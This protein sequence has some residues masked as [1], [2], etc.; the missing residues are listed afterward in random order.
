MFTPRSLPLLLL[1]LPLL[2]LSCSNSSTEVQSA[3]SL[4]LGLTAAEADYIGLKVLQGGH[5]FDASV[6]RAQS[7]ATFE[8]IVGIP[9]TLVATA[10]ELDT[11]VVPQTL[12]A[13]VGNA[14]FTPISGPN[15]LAMAMPVL[16]TRQ[17]TLAG[18]VSGLPYSGQL[19]VSIIDEPTNFVFPDALQTG[20]T[21]RLPQNRPLTLV[22]TSPVTQSAVDIPLPVGNTDVVLDIDIGPPPPP[23]SVAFVTAITRDPT[24]TPPVIT[25]PP[26]FTPQCALGATCDPGLAWQDCSQPLPL[27]PTDATVVVQVHY[28]EAP[29]LPCSTIT[30]TVDRTAPVLNGSLSPSFIGFGSTTPTLT[31]NS[32]EPLF[33]ASLSAT[34]S[35]GP[36]LCISPV[37]L[38]AN[39]Y[40][41]LLDVSTIVTPGDL[42][43]VVSATDTAG[44]ASTFT[45]TL[46][47]L[48]GISHPVIV[49][50]QTFPDIPDLI[51]G[52]FY[53]AVD[54]LNPAPTPASNIALS[55]VTFRRP[56]NSADLNLNMSAATSSLP[57]LAG[58]PDVSS[59]SIG[60][61]WGL[62]NINDNRANPSPGG[63]YQADIQ[64]SYT[65]APPNA[66]SASLPVGL[67]RGD[68]QWLSNQL[69]ISIATPEIPNSYYL[70]FFPHRGREAREFSFA[71]STTDVVV[72]D[73]HQPFGE[74]WGLFGNSVGTTT[75]NVTDTT[76]GEIAIASV[77]LD[78]SDTP[79]LLALLADRLVVRRFT[80]SSGASTDDSI[81]FS[82]TIGTT[83]RLLWDSTRDAA[84]VVG[85]NGT[86]TILSVGDGTNRSVSPPYLAPCGAPA[87]GILDGALTAIQPAT[88]LTTPD[89]ALLID[90]GAGRIHC[91]VDLL[92][93]AQHMS[94]AVPSNQCSNTPYRLTADPLT[95][96]FVA[97]DFTCAVQYHTRTG[98]AVKNAETVVASFG[99]ILNITY[100]PFTNT[101]AAL[102]D[103][104]SVPT[105]MTQTTGIS[106]DVSSAP[107]DIIQVGSQGTFDPTAVAIDPV[108]GNIFVAAINDYIG[109][110]TYFAVSDNRFTGHQYNTTTIV[111]RPA[112]FA[113]KNPVIDPS[114]RTMYITDTDGVLWHVA[115]GSPSGF[116]ANQTA[117][118]AWPFNQVPSE[119]VVAGPQIVALSA[120]TATPGSIVTAIGQGFVGGGADEVFVSGIAA[121]VL[122]STPHAV[123]FRVP[124]QFAQLRYYVA[125]AWVT[126]RSHGRMSGPAP[127]FLEITHDQPAYALSL[128]PQASSLTCDTWCASPPVG[129][130][131]VTGY[132]QLHVTRGNYGYGIDEINNPVFPA[133]YPV[134]PHF[135]DTLPGYNRLQGINVPAAAGPQWVESRIPTYFAAPTEPQRVVPMSAS[136]TNIGPLVIDATGR[137]LAVALDGALELFWATSLTPQSPPA[138][139]RSAPA[140]LSHLAFTPDSQYLVAF[141]SNSQVVAFP[142][143]GGAPSNAAIDT[144][145]CG[146]ASMPTIAVEPRESPSDTDLDFL[147]YDAVASRI[148]AAKFVNNAGAFSIQC[149]ASRPW[150]GLPKAALSPNGKFVALLDNVTGGLEVFYLSD[151]SQIAG[152]ILTPAIYGAVDGSFIFR[153]DSFGIFAAGPMDAATYFITTN[154]ADVGQ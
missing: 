54:V 132:N 153:S 106:I 19:P 94:S 141:G 55:Q 34:S 89:V 52:Y 70:S 130:L 100:D 125:S 85:S 67:Q 17:V 118:A 47:N 61:L 38:G 24:F 105:A 128:P 154:L 92:T 1:I 147:F 91:E 66:D 25:A 58:S 119:L 129:K 68:I 51:S 71:Y 16:P 99:N 146:S 33:L 127:K 2:D 40:S 36:N 18:I 88:S 109:R 95:G 29:G 113:F 143:S 23:P 90:T 28:L 6:D 74:G 93:G 144:T 124:N 3:M 5:E 13:F 35:T 108:T 15:N 78:V 135:S 86:Q 46:R 57:T 97:H 63:T 50:I 59:P 64:I 4:Q 73:A 27:P 39:S 107:I 87:G 69:T 98:S 48:Q 121:T 77:S 140:G 56:N 103:E 137:H 79:L 148:R 41:C 60:R 82:P 49:G 32:S 9:V 11:L 122:S 84:V 10:L 133:A 20:D 149:G 120:P 101:T 45:T 142:L 81:L 110:G 123:T 83:R 138:T 126:V 21:V 22:V 116:A 152:R 112:G 115:I 30:V 134:G 102:Y 14:T 150:I 75:L 80:N 26:G 7:Q 117:G 104:D 96:E 44:N 76:S 139:P 31:L 65:A 145:S 114:H 131:H 42:P 53:V 62:I 72:A 12:S 136:Y 111:P 151:F 37:D 8:V 43:I